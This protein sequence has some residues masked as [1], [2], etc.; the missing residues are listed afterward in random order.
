MRKIYLITVF[1]EQR[2]LSCLHRNVRSMYNVCHLRQKVLK[3]Q[4]VARVCKQTRYTRPSVCLSRPTVFCLSLPSYSI[5]HI[6][7][8]LFAREPFSL[9]LHIT[10]ITMRHRLVC[11]PVV[12]DC[13]DFKYVRRETV[14]AVTSA[15]IP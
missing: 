12:M 13:S 6:A 4:V 10:I 14:V 11:H 3:G 9:V 5:F 1:D 15:H 2:T 8:F 7:A